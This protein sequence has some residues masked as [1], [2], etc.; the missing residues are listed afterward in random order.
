MTLKVRITP[1]ETSIS[2]DEFTTKL[3]ED[4]PRIPPEMFII[5]WI[6]IHCNSIS[7][8]LI[9]H[10]SVHS[11]CCCYW[12]A[13]LGLLQH[14][15]EVICEIVAASLLTLQIRTAK[16]WTSHFLFYNGITRIRARAVHQWA[17]TTIR[18]IFL[19]RIFPVD[20]WNKTNVFFL[21]WLCIF[22]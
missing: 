11:L 15:P 10:T 7:L 4:N 16:T 13:T 21:C 14:D 19:T 17:V 2:F 9:V 18:W 3:R 8:Q 22:G 1:M 12:D 6:W 5:D 20:M